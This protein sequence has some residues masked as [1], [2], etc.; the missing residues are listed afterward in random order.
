VRLVDTGVIYVPNAAGTGAGIWVEFNSVAEAST[1]AAGIVELSTSAEAVTGTDT[2]RA[3]TP[4]AMKAGMADE[5]NVRGYL[6]GLVGNG[7]ASASAPLVV[8]TGDWT[9]PLSFDCP[10][11][12]SRKVIASL[13][14]VGA[15]WGAPYTAAVFAESNALQVVAYGATVSDYTGG[16][17][18]GFAAANAGKRVHMTLVCSAGV[19]T[20]YVDGV[21]QT[22]SSSVLGTAAWNTLANA[23]SMFLG[24]AG[25]MVSFFNGYVSTAGFFNRAFTAAQV[26]SLMKHGVDS[27]DVNSAS[28]TAIND[29]TAFDSTSNAFG[30]GFTAGGA[31]GFTGVKAIGYA[32]AL[33]GKTG[34]FEVQPGQRIRVTGT[35]TRNNGK[36]V[37]PTVA[38]SNSGG[39][40]GYSSGPSVPLITGDGAFDVVLTCTTAATAAYVLFQETGDQDYTIADVAITRQGA[41]LLPEPAAPGNGLVW[42]DVS[43]NG[44]HIVLPTSGVSWALPSNAANRIRGTTN[45]SGNQALLGGGTILPA[46]AQI[47][48]I[49][50]RSR[51]G[52]PTITLGTASA[53]AQL[54]A[55]VALSTTWKDLTIALAGGIVTA[56]DDVWVGSNSTDVVE[57]DITWEPLGF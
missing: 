17:I 40:V 29:V 28:N 20:V 19:L 4:A 57:I 16:Y 49:R 21:A 56:A 42:N 43:G 6:Q 30:A 11:G 25:G 51:S 47:T 48:R 23:T 8:G 5:M 22:L 3:I 54:V 18:S 10:D 53:G 37:I 32:G 50:G 26:L 35:L 44:A 13:S 39:G 36:T 12:S 15:G 14:V 33:L 38:L 2:A 27:A 31:T 52:T 9:W 41:V 46:N 7:T 1:T 34:G 24:S 55:S 45:T